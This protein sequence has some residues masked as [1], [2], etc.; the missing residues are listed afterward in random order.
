MNQRGFC[1]QGSQMKMNIRNRFLVPVL[2]TALGL[3]LARQG[4]AQTFTTLYNFT[5]GSDG[6]G[7]L[8]SLIL[9][10]NTLY[11]TASGGGNGGYGTVFAVNTDGT[12][13]TNLHSFTGGSGGYRPSGGLVLLSNTLYG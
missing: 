10:S 9:S 13:F 5:D 12:G 6:G 3:M 1:V 2:I 11:G 8:A 4:R 7:P